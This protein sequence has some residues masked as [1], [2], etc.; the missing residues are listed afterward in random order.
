[1]RRCGFCLGAGMLL[2]CWLVGEARALITAAWPMTEVL[3]AH[4]FIL[5]AKVEKLDP[6]KLTAVLVA[7]EDLKGK[8]PLRRLPVNLTGDKEAEKLKHTPQIVKR[9]AVDLPLVLFVREK[10][11][12]YIAFAYTN[13]T[14][15]QMIAQVPEGDAKT[16]WK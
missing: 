3:S 11:E 16:V 4:D 1:M 2:L 6:Q 8:F 14:W 10:D 15:F 7:Q 13:G 5:V 12:K 9:L